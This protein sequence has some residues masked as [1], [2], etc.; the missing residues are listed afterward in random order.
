MQKA[1]LKQEFQVSTS[2][3]AR[4]DASRHALH[5]AEQKKHAL[6]VAC[7]FAYAE[8]A[9]AKDAVDKHDGH[10]GDGESLLARAYDHFHL[11]R[12]ALR[13]CLFD[14]GFQHLLLVQTEAA[15]EIRAAGIK[16]SVGDEISNARRELASEV[17]AAHAAASDVA[18][19]RDNVEVLLL[20][21]LQHHWDGLRV[22][23][24]VSVHDHDKIVSS[25][26][27]A[28]HICRA[29]AQLALARVDVNSAFES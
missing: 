7:D 13:L 16:Q 20:L 25:E 17:P 21:L 10:L 27:D 22:V 19:A 9:L 26:L 23:A 29:Q 6:E 5:R 11:K 14:D 28:I 8:L 1:L 18:T 2:P 24:H 3:A 12:V 4:D 15:S